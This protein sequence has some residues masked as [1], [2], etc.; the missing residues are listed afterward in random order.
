[1]S[2]IVERG[3]AVA[4]PRASGRRSARRGSRGPRRRSRRPSCRRSGRGRRGRRSPRG[5]PGSPGSARGS[6]RRCARRRPGRPGRW[7]RCRP[8]RSRR[9]TRPGRGSS[10]SRRAGP[11]GSICAE[12]RAGLEVE[13]PLVRGAAVGADER[14]LGRPAVG[15][16]QVVQGAVA[17]LAGGVEDDR[18]VHH[19]VDEQALGRHERAEVLP[20]AG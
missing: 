16:G 17:G 14:P 6:G 2:R 9:A 13:D 4:P 11:G 12:E 8:C 15:D 10:R 3:V 20:L 7:C 1:M 5:G 19:D 18:H